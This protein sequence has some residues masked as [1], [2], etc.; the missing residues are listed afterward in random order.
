MKIIA[1]MLASAIS[2]STYAGNPVGIFEDHVDVGNPKLA[3]SVIYDQDSQTYTLK[4]SG[5]NIWF[6]RDE[7]HYAYNKIKGD[8]ILTANFAFVG[9][10]VDPHRKIGW[11]VRESLDENASHY[12]AVVHGDGLTVMQWRPL[13]GAFMRDPQDEIF[14]PKAGYQIIQLERQS[15]NI[16]LRAAHVGEP[17]QVIG[18][19]EMKDMPDEVL[20]GLFINSHNSDVVEEA[21]VWKVG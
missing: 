5:Y 18:T 8:F 16:I 3:G 19:A 2:I 1:T 4:G 21:K 12:S 7:F 9:K 11:M 10:G 6:E 14:A 17:L 13:R 20:A 15:K